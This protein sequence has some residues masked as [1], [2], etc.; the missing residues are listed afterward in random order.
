MVMNEQQQNQSGA[1]LK[2]GLG[3]LVFVC[4]ALACSLE[5]FLHEP[6]SFGV[7]YLGMQVLG[8]AGIMFLYPVL[9]PQQDPM[10]LVLYLMCFVGACVVIR[11]RTLLRNARGGTLE[12]SYYSGRPWLLRW[13]PDTAETKIKA[14]AEPLIVCFIGLMVLSQSQPL[15]SY[16][17][18]AALS[19]FVSVNAGIG[20]DRTRML[21][22]NDA[23]LDQRRVL[24][25]LRDR[26]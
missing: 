4:R 10:P 15:G 13:A 17:L 20:F 24:D 16:L 7:R 3:W 8:A 1:Q 18:L 14:G 6:S 19:L 9:C 22:M 23:M 25:E 5:V 12:H 2:T 21:D 11:I 26:S